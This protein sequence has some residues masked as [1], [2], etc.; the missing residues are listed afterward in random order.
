VIVKIH[1]I[2]KEYEINT[3]RKPKS[4]CF[5]LPVNVPST[6]WSKSNLKLARWVYNVHRLMSGSDVTVAFNIFSK[7]LDSYSLFPYVMLPIITVHYI[8]NF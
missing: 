6:C 4:L 5:V 2:L 3:N 8:S 7:I 1:R